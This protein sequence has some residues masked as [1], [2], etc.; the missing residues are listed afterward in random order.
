MTKKIFAFILFTF[1]FST[2][3]CQNFSENKFKNQPFGKRLFLGGNV[4][5]QFGTITLIDLS[6]SLG[7]WVTNR[8]ALGL[9]I[10][11]QYYSDKRWTPAFSTSIYGGNAFGRFYIL[12][13]L[14][15]HLEYQL[16]NYKTLLVDPYGVFNKT[17][18][19][20]EPYYLIGGGYVQSLGGNFSMNIIAL[21]NLNETPYSLYQNPIIRIGFNVGL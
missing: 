14:F 5:L 10:N 11:Y 9:G 20:Y 18:R 2:V 17:K 12:E 7:C 21:Y 8:I 6:P 13:N 16:I 1:L 15:A 19:I 3:F 4:G